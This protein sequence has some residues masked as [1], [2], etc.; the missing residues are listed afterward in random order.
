M[1]TCEIPSALTVTAPPLL[2]ATG[3][4]YAASYSG[5][6]RLCGV[7]AVQACRPLWVLNDLETDITL[8]LPF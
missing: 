6:G 5:Q 1:D 2:V 3:K 8:R 7:S 4:P